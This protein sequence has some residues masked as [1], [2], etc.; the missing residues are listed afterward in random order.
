MQIVRQEPCT[1]PQIQHYFSC[2]NFFSYSPV[3]QYE[4][5]SVQ[6]PETDLI[7]E[8]VPVRE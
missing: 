8:W 7:D 5:L 3:S 4:G 2:T 6:E 1:A